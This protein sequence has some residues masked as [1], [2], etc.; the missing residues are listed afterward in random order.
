MGTGA[1]LMSNP[2]DIT[3]V[4]KRKGGEQEVDTEATP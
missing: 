1:T 2:Q 3:F 4:R